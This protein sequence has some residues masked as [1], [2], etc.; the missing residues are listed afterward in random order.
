MPFA[1]VSATAPWT[2][3]PD[4]DGMLLAPDRPSP[5][6]FGQIAHEV[7]RYTDFSAESA[8]SET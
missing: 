4:V 6:L 3:M 8:D 1:G 7:L 5:R 2:V